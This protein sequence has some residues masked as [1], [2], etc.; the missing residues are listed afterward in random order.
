MKPRKLILIDI[1]EKNLYELINNLNEYDNSG[2][3]K[4]VLGDSGD[5]NFMKQ[6]ISSN[7]VDLIFHTSAY[8]HVNLVENNP[9][10]GLLNNVMSSFVICELSSLLKVPKVILISSDKAVRPKN[11][12]GA[13]KRVSEI[14]F[15]SF[16]N[17]FP[18]TCFSMVR[19][20]NVLNSS[21]SVIPLFKKQIKNLSPITITH[22][23]VTLFHDY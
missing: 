8:K 16:N 4:F 14:L 15:Q 1:N 9:I 11:I 17:Q 19:F 10:Q 23:E 13:S 20:G 21:G 2:I 18:G 12:M 7:N 3:I 5:F 22:P 6:L